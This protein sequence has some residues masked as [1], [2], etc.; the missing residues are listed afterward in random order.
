MI[1]KMVL[2][3]TLKKTYLWRTYG[4][5][6]ISLKRQ[7]IWRLLLW[8][9]GK[10]NN[11][12]RAPQCQWWW[13]NHITLTQCCRKLCQRGCHG[14]WWKR[15][16]TRR[17]HS[18]QRSSSHSHGSRNFRHNELQK[19]YNMKYNRHPKCLTDELMPPDPNI[20]GVS[21]ISYVGTPE[22]IQMYRGT[23]GA[24]RHV[25]GIGHMGVLNVWWHRSIQ[26]AV[27]TP[28]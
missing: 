14:N 4:I 21:P 15:Q 6:G 19:R 8:H 12:S 2:G 25:G 23:W 3:S 20:W 7:Q 11:T 16:H 17:H 22:H 18:H 5:I 9:R 26:G 1:Y 10:A 27:Q 13:Q 28:S 24:Y